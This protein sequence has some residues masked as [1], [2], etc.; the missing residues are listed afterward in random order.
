MV[1]GIDRT[2]WM[3]LELEHDQGF[4]LATDSDV[5]LKGS[6]LRV[7]FFLNGDWLFPSEFL[8]GCLVH[9]DYYKLLFASCHPRFIEVKKEVADDS[10]AVS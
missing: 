1:S 5:R 6:A 2:T 4:S 9:T 10:G 7:T 3:I 8:L